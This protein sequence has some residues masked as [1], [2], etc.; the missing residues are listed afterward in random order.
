MSDLSFVKDELIEN[1][2]IDNQLYLQYQVKRGL[3]NQDGSG[4]LAGLTRISSVVGFHNLDGELIPKTGDLKLRGI[5]LTE[6]I[7]K[8]DSTDRFQFESVCFLLLVGRLPKKNEGEKLTLFMAQ[9]RAIP[10]EILENIIKG[11]PSSDMMNKLQ[12]AISALYA[13]D[14]NPEINDPYQDFLKAIKIIAKIPVIIAY[15]YLATFQKDTAKFVLPPESYSTAESFLYC[16]RNGKKPGAFESHVVDLALVLHAEHGGGNNSTFTTHVVSSSQ[17]D[18]Y[19]TLAAAIASLK[20]P[21]HGSANIKVME[22]MADIKSNVKNWTDANEVSNYLGKIINKEVGDQSG[23]LYGLGHAVYTKS[24][25]RA[26]IIQSIATQIA[27]D[28]NRSEE[29]KLYQFIGETGPH[30]FN[31]I[32][33]SDKVISPNVDFYSGFI[34]DCLKIPVQLYTTIFAM[35]RTAGW[36]AHRIE[37]QLS[38]KR[39]IRPGYKGI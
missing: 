23:K 38:G 31:T 15:S 8:F 32:K 22:M 26:L 30:I 27:K 24:D 19:S 3:R 13:F 28:N 12:T 9:H 33:G 5:S 25:P 10:D 2:S 16:L 37:E 39:I 21:L 6:L 7:S 20:G 29:L 4:V 1:N 11:I 18:I 35:A 17:S 14:S 36:C 34:Y